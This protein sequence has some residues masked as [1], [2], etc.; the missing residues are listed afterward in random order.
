AYGSWGSADGDGNAAGIERNTRGVVLGVDALATDRVRLGLYT[1]YSRSSV[2]LD[3][4]AASADVDSYHLGLYGGTQ[5][6]ME[7]G[8]L[9]LSGGLAH[10]W[11]DIETSRFIGVSGFSDS[12]SADYR[13][14]TFQAFGELGYGIETNAVRLEP[15]INLAHVHTR[16]GSFSESGGAAALSGASSSTDTTFATQGIRAEADLDLGLGEG[17]DEET[18]AR[19]YGTVGWRHAFGDVTPE[20]T[21]AFAG[22]DAFTITGSPLDRNALVLDTGLELDLTPNSTLGVSYQGQFASG[23]EDHGVSATLSVRF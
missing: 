21:H 17:E 15:F 6:A 9:S 19:L 1:G 11:H 13:G 3:G 5:W 7:G 2:D 12:L 18:G 22:S 4:R 10:S 8:T 20:S 14:N 23:M 16:T